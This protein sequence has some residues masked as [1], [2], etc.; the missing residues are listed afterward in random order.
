M[1]WQSLRFCI[2][3]VVKSHAMCHALSVTCGDS[4]PKGRAKITMISNPKYINSAR[5]D[6]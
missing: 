5:R 2:Y 4:S 3:F 1:V 6:C